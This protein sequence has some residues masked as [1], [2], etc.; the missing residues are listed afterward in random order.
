MKSY[1]ENAPRAVALMACLASSA[2]WADQG[3]SQTQG[4]QEGG[5]GET[6]AKP[7]YPRS[8]LGLGPKAAGPFMYIRWAEDWSD[9]AKAPGYKHIGLGG[10]GA[11][12]TL[13]A[14]QRTQ[15]Q[16]TTAPGLRDADAQDQWRVRNV[17]GL[18]AHLSEHVRAFGE[19]NKSW[20]WGHNPGVKSPQQDNQAVVQQLFGEIHGRGRDAAYHLRIGRQEF[21]DGPPNVIHIRPAGNVYTALDGVLG[22][23]DWRNARFNAFS[24][25]TIVYKP[26]GF[27]DSSSKGD[28]FRGVS[29][30]LALIRP[31]SA[32]AD[33][34]FLDPIA[35]ELDRDGKR[36]GQRIGDERR[37]FYG[38][39][40]WGTQGRSQLDASVIRQSGTYGASDISALGI[41][42]TYS[43]GLP[44]ALKPR[45]GF[46]AD[47]T[48]GGGGY[49]NGTVRDF[50]VFNGSIPYF[51]WGNL[52]GPTNLTVL[53]P[54]FRIS[55]SEKTSVVI[56][57]E[58][59]RRSSER[60]AVY[61]FNEGTY[62]GT[63]NV[64]GKDVGQL[65]KTAVSWQVNDHFLAAL[66]SDYLRAGSVLNQ[67]N[68]RDTLFVSVEGQVVF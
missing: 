17:L 35:W 8:A 11:Y 43:L 56:E 38:A 49:G 36:W 5:R 26:G 62:A 10:N 63:Q 15:F 68:Y 30:S 32:A 54:T 23:M 50:S 58:I 27:D 20:V 37:R 2:A 3:P 12:L 60:D 59:L 53:A 64:P 7:I 41:F 13:S 45:I 52:I 25:K 16:Y 47:Y 40:L 51:T 48:S 1:F 14:E 6:A 44:G 34:L 33:S 39:R 31:D 61:T 57:Y 46:H 18:D 65:I 21:M 19:L 4:R 67:A 66:K 55:P 28:R 22:G 24:F 29:A 9:A 42:S